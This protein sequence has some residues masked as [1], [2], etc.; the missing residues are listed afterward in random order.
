MTTPA[1]WVWMP[2]A[3]HFC[4]GDWCRFHLATYLG[5]G[6]LVSTVGE[7]YPR[8]PGDH[9]GDAPEPIRHDRTYET[10]V[11]P[12]RPATD[13][14]RCC[15]WRMASVAELDFAGYNDPVGATRGH[16]EMCAKWAQKES[17]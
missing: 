11:F 15:P 4:G 17:T 14:N 3:A 6:Y 5:N 1:D 13:A 12:A 7:Y 10:M 8:Y 2:H 16:L 9:E